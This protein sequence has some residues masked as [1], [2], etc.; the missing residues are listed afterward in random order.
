MNTNKNWECKDKLTYIKIRTKDNMYYTLCI[1][2]WEEAAE[3]G[4]SET[5]DSIQEYVDFVTR[6]HIQNIVDNND[7]NSL[8]YMYPENKAVSRDN[9]KEIFTETVISKPPTNK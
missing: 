2:N 7:G 8:I 9:I 1:I 6:R 3:Q 4:E 5:F